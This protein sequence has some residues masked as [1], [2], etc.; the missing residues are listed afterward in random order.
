MAVDVQ[1]TPTVTFGEAV[2]LVPEIAHGLALADRYYDITPDGKQLLVTVPD[3]TDP[4]SK[5]VD[6]VLNWTEELNR[7]VPRQ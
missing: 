4:R 2:V 6:V 5:E 3:R 1:T 7:L